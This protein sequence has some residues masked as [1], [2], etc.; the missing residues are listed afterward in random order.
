MVFALAFLP[1]MGVIVVCS[2]FATNTT[3]LLTAKSDGIR[4]RVKKEA[5][6]I[7]IAQ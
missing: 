1:Y 5:T 2:V 6:H 7:L 3:R 4:V